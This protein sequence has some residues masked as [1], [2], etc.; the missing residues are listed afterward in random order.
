MTLRTYIVRQ[1]ILDSEQQVFG[2]EI[3]YNGDAPESSENAEENLSNTVEGFLMQANSEAFLSDGK[4]F[5][6]FSPNLLERKIP[7]LFDRS[8]LVIQ[9]DEQTLLNSQ[10]KKM[11]AQYHDDGYE[12]AI[13]DFV[14]VSRHFN[15]LDFVDYIKLNFSAY[16]RDKEQYDNIVYLA[17]EFGK[18]VIA[19]RVE[20]EEDLK[21]ARQ[22]GVEYLQGGAVGREV[23]VKAQD[24]NYL[25]SNFFLLLVEVT[26]DEP[27]MSDIEQIISR[28]VTLTYSLLK[29][30]NSAYFALRSKVQSIRQALGIL[31]IDQLKQWIYLL[32][33][34]NGN[35]EV[36]NE[37]IRA[38]FLRG[39]FCEVLLPYANGVEISPS[40]AYLM[41]MF[42][43]LDV[44]MDAPLSEVLAELPISDEVKGALVERKGICGVLFDLVLSYEQAN[45]A[46]MTELS[47]KL[48]IPLNIITQ[49]YFECVESVN[50]IWHKL[51]EN[52]R[53]GEKEL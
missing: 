19:Y 23:K 13:Y 29:L 18:K 26:R 49:K 10:A 47:E 31:G 6:T 40:E 41:G 12:V 22:L 2:Y 27:K 34:K 46:K 48:Q 32:T 52:Q 45:W 53:E 3:L 21:L 51:T 17:R 50:E 43:T 14:F 30:V 9:I 11:V 7:D 38:S 20:T 15:T 25:Q 33:F 36:S 1:P 5:F 39:T 24:Y 28:D 44:L 16:T 42:S 4:A 35:V 8:R 37:L